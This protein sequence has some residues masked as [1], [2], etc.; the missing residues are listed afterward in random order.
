MR[1]ICF[2]WYRPIGSSTETVKRRFENRDVL[3]S[4]IQLADGT[5]FNFDVKA[6]KY[7]YV[8]QRKPAAAV[9]HWNAWGDKRR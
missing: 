6:W 4:L 8:A 1:R 2:L 7:W 9:T 5:S 3:E